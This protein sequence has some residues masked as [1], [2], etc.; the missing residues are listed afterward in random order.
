MKRI[1][2]QLKGLTCVDCPCCGKGCWLHPELGW[3]HQLPQCRWFARREHAV[4]E[5]PRARGGRPGPESEPV[6][7]ISSG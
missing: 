2:I 6:K 4:S 5:K 7:P 1:R 3:L